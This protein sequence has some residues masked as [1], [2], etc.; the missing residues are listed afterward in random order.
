M[1]ILIYFFCAK[2]IL[3]NIVIYFVDLLSYNVYKY[4]SI[5]LECI[6]TI[7]IKNYVII[8]NS[9]LDKEQANKFVLSNVNLMSYGN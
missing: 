8:Y 5:C 6:S 3:T 9:H 1:A 2:P 7:F 4:F